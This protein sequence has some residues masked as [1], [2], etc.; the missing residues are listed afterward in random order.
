MKKIVITGG[1]CGG[2]TTAESY[3]RSAFEKLGYRVIFITEASTELIFSGI[4]PEKLGQKDYQR[5]VAELQ[6][7]HETVFCALAEKQYGTE[8]TLV[9]CDRGIADGS[10]YFS[11]EDY[12]DVL[13]EFGLDEEAVLK[14]Y[15]GVFHLVTAARGAESFYTLGNNG[16]RREDACEAGDL[17][18][19]L[20]EAWSG[21]PH[22]RM[23]GNDGDFEE[24]MTR[25]IAEIAA[26]L[27]E[28]VP[29]ENP[30]YI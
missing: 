11:K 10:A 5:A 15:D 8:K 30:K 6:I 9:V 12:R 26:L 28:A 17:D 19:R 3:I 24:K 18:D 2:K 23:I 13:S 4:T 27:G 29:G 20:I 16:A 14:R 7:H 21:H 1:P 25:L 22:F